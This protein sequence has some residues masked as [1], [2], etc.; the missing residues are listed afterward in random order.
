VNK[1]M[2]PEV[3]DKMYWIT[4]ESRKGQERFGYVQHE[5][6]FPKTSLTATTDF[7]M[8]GDVRYDLFVS[9]LGHY[10]IVVNYSQI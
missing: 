6:D 5:V 2:I 1:K 9:N 4:L 10:Y 3:I 7:I 8:I